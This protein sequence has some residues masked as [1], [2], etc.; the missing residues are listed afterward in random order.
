L[1]RRSPLLLVFG[2]LSALAGSCELLVSDT[3][4]EVQCTEEGAIGQPACPAG[5]FCHQGVCREGPP[6]LGEPCGEGL[7][8]SAGDRCLDPT[9][10]GIDGDEFCSHPCCS[11]ADCGTGA[12]ADMVCVAL[13]PG[14]TCV[15]AARLGR[16]PTGAGFGGEPCDEGSECRSGACSGQGGFCLDGCCSDVE[17]GLFGDACRMAAGG[18]TCLPRTDAKKPYLFGCG[19]DK[20]CLSGLCVEWPD[21]LDRCSEP[22]CSSAACGELKAADGAHRVLCVAKARDK[23]TVYA[24]AALAGGDAIRGLG[25]PCDDAGQCRGGRCIDAGVNR[26]ATG[27]GPAFKVC[28]DVCCTD[29]SC[30]A[31]GLFACTPAAAASGEPPGADQQGFGLQCTRR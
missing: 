18:W 11:S 29:A 22:C 15:P 28:S 31:P 4:P 10:L 26:P 8:C 19:A 6:A 1:K 23:T 14:K 7:G 12:G 21:G 2:A 9:S 24:C 25:E 16:F 17:C 30:G 27:G 5:A 13:G 20:E 3:L